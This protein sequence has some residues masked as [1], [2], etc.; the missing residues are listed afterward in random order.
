[1]ESCSASSRRNTWQKKGAEKEPCKVPA[2]EGQ[3]GIGY[4]EGQGGVAIFGKKC[5]MF[6][7]VKPCI[8]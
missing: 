6:Y 2:K 3:A 4:E 7:R 8:Q 1:M 5:F